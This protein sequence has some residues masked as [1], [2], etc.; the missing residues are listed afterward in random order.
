[1]KRQRVDEEVE[2]EDEDL[3]P[4]TRTNQIA[5]HPAQKAGLSIALQEIEDYIKKITAE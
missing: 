2:S 4:L 1:M 3:E 5:H